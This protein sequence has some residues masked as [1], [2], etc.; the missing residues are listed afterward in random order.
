M[1]SPSRAGGLEGAAQL[2]A[3][4]RGGSVVY[5]SMPP[6]CFFSFCVCLQCGRSQLI[7]FMTSLLLLATL[8][9]IRALRPNRVTGKRFGMSQVS[10]GS[11]VM[12]PPMRLLTMQVG[13][14][15]MQSA[16]GSQAQAAGVGEIA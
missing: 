10:S 16:V 15:A 14:Q 11:M 12:R 6:P 13:Q 9:D 8:T 3:E 2:G 1:Q 5:Q 7:R 4:H